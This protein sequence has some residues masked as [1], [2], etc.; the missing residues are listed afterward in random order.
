MLNDVKVTAEFK[1]FGDGPWRCH[2]PLASHVGEPVV[3]QVAYHTDKGV[4]VGRFSCSCGYVFSR[5]QGGKP[6]VIE[7]GPAFEAQLTRCAEE[8]MSL[9]AAARTLFVSTKTVIHQA[10]RLGIRT[11]W[12]KTDDKLAKS[13]PLCGKMRKK[14]RRTLKDNP[15]A[16]VTACRKMTPA[17][18]AWLYRNDRAW[19]M[20]H[21]PA[22][23][24]GASPRRRIR[25]WSEIDEATVGILVALADEIRT[26]VPPVRVSVAQ[27]ERRMDRPGWFFSRRNKLPRCAK[28]LAQLAEPVELFQCRRVL[29]AVSQLTAKGI[30]ITDSNLRRWAGLRKP[31]APIVEVFVMACLK[32]DVCPDVGRLQV[33]A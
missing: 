33:A 31:M 5:K 21:R 3:H 27:L 6:V 19:L 13:G 23:P 22:N 16:S 20:S 2:N 7:F 17:C 1:P 4:P 25:N 14:W 29:W 11:P 9:R 26:E 24:N 18:Y 12:T 10:K 8:A 28:A 30:S 15:W 32:E